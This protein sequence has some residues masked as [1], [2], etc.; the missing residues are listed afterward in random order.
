M[1]DTRMVIREPGPLEPYSAAPESQSASETPNFLQHLLRSARDLP[2]ERRI[3]IEALVTLARSRSNQAVPVDEAMDMQVVVW[4]S[5]IK[6]IPTE[7]F[8]EA[9][10]LANRKKDYPTP[11]T[12][13]E[14]L[15]AWN[16]RPNRL[17]EEREELDKLDYVELPSEEEQIAQIIATK[18]QAYWDRYEAHRAAYNEQL[19]KEEEFRAHVQRER[20]I[21]DRIRAEK[22]L[23]EK[24]ESSG[25]Q[26]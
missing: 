13:D 25:I 22:A 21:G 5:A 18:G 14:M 23:K 12:P 3:A 24:G 8:G 10:D 17:R 9:I 11:L 6:A 16:T 19:R 20:A 2:E 26:S 4:E 1:H 7:R 15:V